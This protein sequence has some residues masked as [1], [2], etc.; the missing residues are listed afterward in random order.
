MKKTLITLALL[1]PLT[2]GQAQKVAGAGASYG[3]NQNITFGGNNFLLIG[4]STDTLSDPIVAEIQTIRPGTFLGIEYKAKA[5]DSANVG[6]TISIQ[7]RTCGNPQTGVG[8]PNQWLVPR[9]RFFQNGERFADTLR[10]T[11][12]PNDTTQVGHYTLIPTG[13]QWRLRVKG[14]GSS[15]VYMNFWKLVGY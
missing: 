15:A 13:N 14:G 12:I 11:L 3:L 10:V 9:F 7:S 6:Y 2:F 5:A 8:C 1:A 4:S